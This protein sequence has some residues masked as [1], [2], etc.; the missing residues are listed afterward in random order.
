MRNTE[1]KSGMKL[2]EG[3]LRLYL[4]ANFITNK[5][6]SEAENLDAKKNLEVFTYSIYE[7]RRGDSIKKTIF[8]RTS[9][10]TYNIPV[11]HYLEKHAIKIKLCAVNAFGNIIESLLKIEEIKLL[12]I[13]LILKNKIKKYTIESST[14][15]QFF[16]FSKRL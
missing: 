5:L 11:Y 10:V 8:S 12:T 13:I 16:L 9:L 7:E 3:I 1:N 2:I 4:N 14:T 15:N 6:V